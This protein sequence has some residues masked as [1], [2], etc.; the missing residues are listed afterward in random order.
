[1]Q[2][3]TSASAADSRSSLF[4]FQGSSSVRDVPLRLDLEARLFYA[5]AKVN[6][7]LEFPVII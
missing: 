2:G 6:T 4:W 1:M 3:E 7:A 5:I